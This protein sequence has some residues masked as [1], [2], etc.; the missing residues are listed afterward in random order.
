VRTKILAS[1]AASS[2]VS[3]QRRCSHSSRSD[4]EGRNKSTP[5]PSI[6]HWGR[7]WKAE[8]RTNR[9]ANPD[10]G[11]RVIGAAGRER[12]VGTAVWRS[13]AQIRHN[14]TTSTAS[15]SVGAI[16]FE[17]ARGCHQQAAE[18]KA[19]PHGYHRGNPRTLLMWWTAPAPWR[20]KTFAAQKHCSFLR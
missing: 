16:V 4:A 18:F 15:T 8:G 2:N 6:L 3:T 14:K 17:L 19:W 13:F 5:P 9:R 20:L 12:S 10:R 7:E 11:L 1:P